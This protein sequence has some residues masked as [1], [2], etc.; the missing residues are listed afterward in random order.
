VRFSDHFTAA[1]KS[2]PVTCT[3]AGEAPPPPLPPDGFDDGRQVLESMEPG[4][5]RA[6]AAAAAAAC[7]ARALTSRDNAPE[8]YW[9]NAATVN[10]LLTRKQIA[11][12]K[13]VL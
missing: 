12:W 10:I 2:A 11:A 5:E 9:R 7:A 1:D 6:A 4:E 3:A 13:P 8:A